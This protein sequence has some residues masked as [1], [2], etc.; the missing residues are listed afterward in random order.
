MIFCLTKQSAHREILTEGRFNPATAQVTSLP[1]WGNRDL[2]L[3]TIRGA[4]RQLGIDWREF[5][6][7]CL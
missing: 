3:G 4:I 7:G 1:D 6:P 2:K 5:D